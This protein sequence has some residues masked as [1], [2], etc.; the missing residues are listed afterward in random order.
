MRMIRGLPVAILRYRVHNPGHSTAKVGI[1][2]SI[3]NPV[4]PE[5][6]VGGAARSVQDSRLNEYRKSGEL[7][8]LLMS[9]PSVPAGDPLQGSFALAALTRRSR[10]DQLLARLAPGTLVEFTHAVLGCIFPRRATAERTGAAQCGG[11]R[12]PAKLDT[13]RRIG[14]LHFSA[15]MELS[16]SHTRLVRLDCS[17]RRRQYHHWQLLCHPFQGCLGSCAIHCDEFRETRITDEGICEGLWR[18]HSAFGG[19]GSRQRKSF[20]ARVDN[21]LPD[22]RWRVPR[23]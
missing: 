2:F 16:Q 20:D 9:N 7:E 19:E 23:F 10:C 8:G 17:Y 13:C 11:S 21:L 15:F 3:D 14:K 1:A 5:P 18:E 12:L 4:K 22:C 6:R